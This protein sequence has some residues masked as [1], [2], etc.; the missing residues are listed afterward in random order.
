MTSAQVRCEQREALEL[1]RLQLLPRIAARRV[2]QALGA[3]DA[4]VAGDDSAQARVDGAL[5]LADAQFVVEQAYLAGA[6][7]Q[8]AEL[9]DPVEH[10]GAV[11]VAVATGHGR[12]EAVLERLPGIA[13]AAIQPPGGQRGE[14]APE[15]ART[16]AMQEAQV[17]RQR[18]TEG[19]PLVETALA[20]ADVR[21][22]PTQPL[23]RGS[24]GGQ[25]EVL[26][27]VGIAEQVLPVVEGVDP[28]PAPERRRAFVE[29]VRLGE[30]GIAVRAQL[31]AA[32]EARHERADRCRQEAQRELDDERLRI[33]R[34]L[35]IDPPDEPLEHLELGVDRARGCRV[36][37]DRAPPRALEHGRRRRDRRARRAPRRAQPP[38]PVAQ[39]ADGAQRQH[40]DRQ[41]R[42]HAERGRHDRAVE[43]DEVVTGD[44][45]TALVDVHAADAVDDA[46]ARIV[47]HPAAAERVHGEQRPG[48]GADHA[49][50]VGRDR[51]PERVREH[52]RA[53]LA[54][55]HEALERGDLAR[56]QR[57]IRQTGPSDGDCAVAV[58]VVERVG[59]RHDATGGA[60]VTHH[61]DDA[62]ARDRVAV[63]RGRIAPVVVL[64]VAPAREAAELCQ[65]VGG[66]ERLL[67]QPAQRPRNREFL[68]RDRLE[69]IVA[70]VDESGDGRSDVAQRRRR[71]LVA[72]RLGRV[73]APVDG[74][75]HVAIAREALAQRRRQD[76]PGASRAQQQLRRAERAGGQH[77]PARAHRHRAL[78][79]AQLVVGVVG[80]Q[81]P[82]GAVVCRL[83]PD[84]GRGRV[85]LD[86]RARGAREQVHV[87]RILGAEVAAGRAVAAAHAGLERHTPAR[88][89]RAHRDRD[90]HRSEARVRRLVREPLQRPV[91]GWRAVG[92]VE[93]GVG[94]CCG[95]ARR[96][97]E[98]ASAGVP[99][100]QRVIGADLG[101]P[102]GSREDRF[103]R[104]EHHAG[105]DERATPQPA[106]DQ[107]GDVGA[108]THVEQAL[109]H[110]AW[111]LRLGRA[112]PHVAR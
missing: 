95:R 94:R 15:R 86:T 111:R 66:G 96:A 103:G 93:D 59:H 47:G 30:V 106:G 52:R 68:D 63:D 75:D 67:E 29:R 82:A 108:G 104:R 33:A 65:R 98:H 34:D 60:V 26:A 16:R 58:V 92:V 6:A 12:P 3:H 112:E 84:R 91:L 18:R 61:R 85:D 9:A 72:D 44:P 19:R 81:S 74:G 55:G 22:A 77:D 36:R 102:A 53:G 49:G 70:Q 39:R 90:R 89:A 7:E 1:D 5:G 46:R 80:E 13:Q 38:D 31:E 87:E 83:E 48:R 4:P 50:D 23:G 8:R 99:V 14:H 25:R 105:I 40:G 45:A 62:R 43:D 10:A 56:E 110:A 2:A 88:H 21:L 71:V 32:V 42:V 109:A 17:A 27:R 57:V 76:E 54:G 79:T 20:V 35:E 37:I 64:T 101:R 24:P 100:R 78:A 51:P 41:R 11:T 69:R 73:G 28:D 107:G 97:H